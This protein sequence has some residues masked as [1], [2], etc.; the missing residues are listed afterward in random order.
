MWTQDIYAW[1]VYSI[2][3]AFLSALLAAKL[4]KRQ[5][6]LTPLTLFSIAFTFGHV[7]IASHADYYAEEDIEW[8]YQEPILNQLPIFSILVFGGIIEL[9]F[10][11]IKFVVAALR[12]YRRWGSLHP[13]MMEED[14]NSEDSEK[15]KAIPNN[16]LIN[17]PLTSPPPQSSLP[18]SSFM[19]SISTVMLWVNVSAI[20]IYAIVLIVF[21]SCKGIMED[22]QPPQLISAICITIMAVLGVLNFLVIMSITLQ[23]LNEIKRIL[24]Q[25]RQDAYVLTLISFLFMVV[26]INTAIISWM[27]VIQPST[28]KPF[29]SSS[30][31]ITGWIIFKSFTVYLPL[32]LLLIFCH[33][34]GSSDISLLR[35]TDQAKQ[36][37]EK[38][39]NSNAALMNRLHSEERMNKRLMLV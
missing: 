30:T 39:N 27:A 3:F 1:I 16:E 23:C 17:I 6:H 36:A 4:I 24:Q 11:Y 10:I 7:Y 28:L 13:V 20:V 29:S 33:L 2:V 18:L 15:T 25:N 31:D 21:L 12:N 14:S 26:M 34:K 8:I 5:W 37:E 35:E 38:T 22:S 32:T 9:Q 19:A